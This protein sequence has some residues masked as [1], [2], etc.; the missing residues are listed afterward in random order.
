MRFAKKEQVGEDVKWE[1]RGELLQ[2]RGNG[3]DGTRLKPVCDLTEEEGVCLA[4]VGVVGRVQR[5]T[6]WVECH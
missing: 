1:V 2:Q 5:A 4:E 6:G 3:V